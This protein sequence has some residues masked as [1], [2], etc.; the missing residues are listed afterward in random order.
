MEQMQQM[1]AQDSGR[2]SK[3]IILLAQMSLTGLRS[4]D[5]ASIFNN[6]FDGLVE[7]I[8]MVHTVVSRR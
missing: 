2:E 5:D 4:N 3:V 8:V 6:L 1:L 7:T